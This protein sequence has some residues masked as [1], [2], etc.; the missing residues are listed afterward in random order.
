MGVDAS[1]N[2]WVADSNNRVQLFD[3]NL[4]FVEQFTT[5]LSQPSN[6]EVP[7][8]SSS[9]WTLTVAV[10]ADTNDIIVSITTL[11]FDQVLMRYDP[12]VGK[13]K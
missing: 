7:I 5:Y 6:D 8:S 13:F 11:L 1:H 2:L 9:I 10:D 12:V 4:N 3:K